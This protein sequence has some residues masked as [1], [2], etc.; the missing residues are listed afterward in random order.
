M[1]DFALETRGVLTLA[2]A[3]LCY[4]PCGNLRRPLWTSRPGRAYV[5]CRQRKQPPSFQGGDPRT[6]GARERLG[7]ALPPPPLTVFSHS[8]TH[9]RKRR[10]S[11]RLSTLRADGPPSTAV[12]GYSPFPSTRTLHPRPTTSFLLC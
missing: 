8:E 5:W 10:G 11:V 3:S 6:G 4:V 12:L 1:R 9:R 2:C 7:E